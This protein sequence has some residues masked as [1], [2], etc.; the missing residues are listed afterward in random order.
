MK[1]QFDMYKQ[2]TDIKTP[3]TVIV[4]GQ[5]MSVITAQPDSKSITFRIPNDMQNEVLRTMRRRDP[6]RLARI[7]DEVEDRF[8]GFD[9]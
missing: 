6:N 3:V 8:G 5:N 7:L 1:A 4:S 2:D 9:D